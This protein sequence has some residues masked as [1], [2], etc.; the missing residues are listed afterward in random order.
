MATTIMERSREIG[1]VK[2]LGAADWEVYLL[3]LSESAVVGVVGGLLGCAAGAGLS[4]I[5]GLSVFG[6]T[7]AFNPIVIPVN[8]FISVM[9]AL[10]GSLMPSRLITRLYPAEVL[11]GRR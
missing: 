7:V 4:Q 6:S 1:L 3:F 9:I 2:A 5:I 11:H 8:L 10:A